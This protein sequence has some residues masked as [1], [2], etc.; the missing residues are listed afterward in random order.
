MEI[1]NLEAML[2]AT[3]CRRKFRRS[4]VDTLRVWLLLFAVGQRCQD[5]R[6]L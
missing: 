4:S 6:G 5:F 3:A 2:E 1:D